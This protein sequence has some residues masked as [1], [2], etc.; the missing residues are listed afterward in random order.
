MFL[1]DTAVRR[2]RAGEVAAANHAPS[3]DARGVPH[4]AWNRERIDRAHGMD[5]LA[6]EMNVDFSLASAEGIAA[7]AL[8]ADDDGIHRAQRVEHRLR[9]NPRCGRCCFAYPMTENPGIGRLQRGM[10]VFDP[11]LQ[12]KLVRQLLLRTRHRR[13]E[14]QSRFGRYI[15]IHGSST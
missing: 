7:D 15:H 1:L 14:F 11:C 6:G 12:R 13:F 4:H 9:P 8:L 2:Q 5:T 3:Y 10:R